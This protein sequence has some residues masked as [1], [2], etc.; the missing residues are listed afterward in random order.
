METLTRAALVDAVRREIGLPYSESK[1]FVAA[2]LEETIECLAA[3]ETVKIG[4]FGS[5]V[6]YDKG[7]RT[8]RNPKTGAPAPIPARRV[9]RFIP[10]KSLRKQIASRPRELP[11]GG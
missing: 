10:S 3:G 7:P 6:P 2:V 9:V 11:G 4:S 5:F 8:G 1:C